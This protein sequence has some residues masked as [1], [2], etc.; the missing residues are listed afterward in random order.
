MKKAGMIA[1]CF[2]FAGLSCRKD[3]APASPDQPSIHQSY[4]ATL[5]C[6]SITTEF[7]ADFNYS[8]NKSI[9]PSGYWVTSNNYPMTAQTNGTVSTPSTGPHYYYTSAMY[10]FN[11][12]YFTLKK[13][14]GQ[15][16]RNHINSL[17]MPLI[18]FADPFASVSKNDTLRVYFTGG[19]RDA[20]ESIRIMIWQSTSHF[21]YSQQPVLV[22]D[23]VVMLY[24]SDMTPLA[25]GSATLTI[26]RSGPGIP[27]DEADGS[28]GGSMSIHSKAVRTVNILN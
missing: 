5:N 24:P 14:N 3:E 10:G 27:L 20:A 17:A 1:L 7:R 8:T 6:T 18:N 13:S 22:G 23:S 19:P 28:A 2:C 16:L 12:A 15:T 4:S 11:D 25:T 26:T 9:L 21:T